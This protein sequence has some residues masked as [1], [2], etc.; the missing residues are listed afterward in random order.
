MGE[1]FEGAATRVAAVLVPRGSDEIVE[2]TGSAVRPDGLLQTTA[3][4]C[5]TG[6]RRMARFLPFLPT[7]FP[8]LALVRI[9]CGTS[10]T[11]RRRKTSRLTGLA[12]LP[13]PACITAV[14][15]LLAFTAFGAAAEPDVRRVLIAS[16]PGPDLTYSAGDRISVTVQFHERVDVA[17][18][19]VLAIGIG[20]ATRHA[21]MWMHSGNRLHFAY[22]VDAADQDANGISVDA[23]ALRLNGGSGRRC[24]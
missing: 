5:A 1:F 19:P 15:T 6:V 12:P 14:A 10:V 13:G 4:S 9:S 18:V 23:G 11:A 2:A 16:S 8:R 22:T 17:G 7:A 24:T 20:N 21:P 3:G